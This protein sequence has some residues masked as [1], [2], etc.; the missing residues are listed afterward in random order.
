MGT[1]NFR[2]RAMD[3]LPL[4]VVCA[5]VLQILFQLVAV[6]SIEIIG[7]IGHFALP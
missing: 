5:L 3:A 7:G 6:F 4:K 2:G 1:D